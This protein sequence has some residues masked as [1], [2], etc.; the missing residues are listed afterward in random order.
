ME[1]NFDT[2]RT[3]HCSTTSKILCSIHNK[4]NSL[5]FQQVFKLSLP[6]QTN[7]SVLNKSWW[8]LCSRQNI[9]SVRS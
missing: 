1:V 3:S 4:L 2:I 6:D 9:L 7:I 5:K 8:W